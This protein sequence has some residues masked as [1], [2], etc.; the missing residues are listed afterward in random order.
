[1]A[2]ANRL[3]LQLE[4]VAMFGLRIKSNQRRLWCWGL[5]LQV[6]VLW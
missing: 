6:E 4:G 2:F 1:M 5:G 3:Q